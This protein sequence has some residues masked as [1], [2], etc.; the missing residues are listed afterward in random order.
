MSHT[1]VDIVRTLSF[2][3]DSP[4]VHYTTRERERE[5]GKEG[6][7]EGGREGERG[8]L[9]ERE[10]ERNLTRQEVSGAVFLGMFESYADFGVLWIGTDLLQH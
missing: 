3:D 8:R 9:R 1:G 10:R 6:G 4:F 2:D 7:R 5:G